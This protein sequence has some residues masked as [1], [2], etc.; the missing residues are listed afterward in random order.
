MR[1]K[2]LL[3]NYFFLFSLLLLFT[4]DHFFKANYS[5]WLTGK[6]PDVFGVI[7]L[8]FLLAYVITKLKQTY[9]HHST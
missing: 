8:T 7:V 2:Y 5:N 1:N 9:V 3:A 4:N 6:L